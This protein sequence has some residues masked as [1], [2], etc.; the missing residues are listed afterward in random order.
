MKENN[1]IEALST[2]IY[3]KVSP[4]FLVKMLPKVIFLGLDEAEITFDIFSHQTLM[5]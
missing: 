1:P 5:N 4:I 3:G 2:C